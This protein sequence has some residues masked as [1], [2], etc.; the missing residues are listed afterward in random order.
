MRP[1]FVLVFA[2]LCYT[3]AHSQGSMLPL[4]N[5]AYHI[6][7]RLAI[8]T[9]LPTPQHSAI[10]Y[11]SRAEVVQFAL[12]ID[13]LSGL[14]LSPR[15]R[16][17]LEYIFLDNNEWVGQTQLDYLPLTQKRY[18]PSAPTLMEQAL[19]NEHF[20]RSKR[21]VV[22]KRLY[23]TP[24]NLFEVNEPHF[25]FRLNPIIH[26]RYGPMQNEDQPVFFNQRGVEAR[27]G[28]DDRVYLHFQ[29]LETQARFPQYVND[30]ISTYKA[31]PGNG[32]YKPY[33]SDV[34]NIR[35][36]YDFL[37]SQ[38]Y[39]GFNLSAHIG[40]QWGYGRH[41]IGNGYRSLLL[42]DFSNNYLYLKLNW[43]VWRFHYQNIFAEL[44]AISANAR[45]GDVILPKKYYAA[46]HLSIDI[47]PNFNVGLFEAVVYNRNNQ[48][49]LGYLNPFILYRAVEQGL[50]SPDNVLIGAD[51]RWDLFKRVQLY[52][53]LMLDEFVF[54]ELVLERRGWWANKFG[55]QAGIKYMDALGIDHLDL[56]AELNLV[57]PYTYTHRDS[58]AS[59]THYNQP[60]AHPL[61][62]NFQEVMLRAQYRPLNRLSL[63]ARL[64][65]IAQ[66][67]EAPGLNYGA[68]LLLPH[69]TRVSDYGV[70]LLQ[71]VRAD[72]WLAVCDLSYQ[73]RH[74]LW[75]EA[76]ILLRDKVSQDETRSQNTR[77]FNLGIRWNADRL[78][79]EF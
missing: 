8:K 71:G 77:V 55:I 42:S 58:S 64:F 7:D 66:G 39:V 61:G 51:G 2:L 48:L 43:K 65:L 32:L 31:L 23:Q 50:G 49:E 11:Y 28:I 10:K 27:A 9:G 63:D 44:N 20:I 37:N 29:L 5:P 56:Q 35:Q 73:L 36:G 17:D 18:D 21:P 14:V 41:F 74:N 6:I 69:T 47:F 46:H 62:A 26:L 15:D 67:E 78:R 34:F 60:L 4:G 75:L 76:Q 53:Q 68:N 19:E 12:R 52:G 22:K 45:T 24:A 59:Y 38:G 3:Q 40:L 79:M 16:Q 30:W 1:V 25:H 70:N 13:T 72:T 54:K 57:R 33:N